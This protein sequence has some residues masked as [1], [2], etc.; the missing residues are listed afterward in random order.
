MEAYAKFWKLYKQVL[1]SSVIRPDEA[2]FIRLVFLE[3][4]RENIEIPEVL[5]DVGCG[6]GRVSFFFGRSRYVKKLHL[7]D[8]SDSVWLARSRFQAEG[9][10]VT[11]FQTDFLTGTR[12][13]DQNSIVLAIG[14]INFLPDQYE[15]IHNLI[16]KQPKIIFLGVT[17]YG[18]GGQIYK[19]LNIFRASARLMRWRDKFIDH[20]DRKLSEKVKINSIIYQLLIQVIKFLEPFVA[21]TIY[22]LKRDEYI[23]AFESEGYRLFKEEEL[24]LCRWFVFVRDSFE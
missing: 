11:C 24:G 16:S 7:S 17:G 8:M 15:A 6:D 9:L 10:K 3:L 18:M 5:Y 13:I 21:S 14:V 20:L 22:W 4:D 23:G 1:K 12:E 2:Q 19:S